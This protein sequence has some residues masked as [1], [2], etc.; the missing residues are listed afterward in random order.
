MLQLNPMNLKS[1]NMGFIGAGK[2]GTSLAWALHSAGFHVAGA[3]S[4]HSN[5]TQ[6]NAAYRLATPISAKVY[7][8]AQALVNDCQVVWLTVPDDSIQSI[9]NQLNWRAGQCV[10][11]CSG[12]TPLT[13]MAHAANAE[14]QQGSAQLAGFHPLKTVSAIPNNPSA[15]AS[16]F[17]GCTIGIEAQHS[18]IANAKDMWAETLLHTMA[19]QLGANTLPIPTGQRALYHASANYAG[20]FI[21]ALLQEAVKQWQHIGATPA[22]ALNALL[23][24]LKSTVAACE[25]AQL[26]KLPLASVTVGPVIRGDVGTVKAHLQALQVFDDDTQTIYKALSKAIVPLGLTK[27]SLTQEQAKALMELLSQHMATT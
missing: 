3:F 9:C 13:A 18:T 25:Q 21:S 26:N 16:M 10:I 23:P 17:A 8:T 19:A 24:L 14:T 22:Q 27:K 1:I 20:A 12:A 6:K 5:A 11:H 15:A 2:V 4:R 7:D